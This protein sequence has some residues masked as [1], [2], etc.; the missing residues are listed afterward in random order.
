M[1]VGLGPGDVVLDGE[2]ASPEK[3]ARPHPI[4]GLCPLWPNGWMDQDT[5]WYEVNLGPDDVVLDEVAAS[6]KRGTAPVFGP[7]L[8]WPNGWLMKTPLGTELDLG[9][10]HFVL[11]G[12]AAPHCQRGTA[13]LP[14]FR[15]MS[16]MATI[17]NLSY[18]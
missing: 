16:I 9:P 3:K 15:P 8:L 1:E 12:D 17:T 4:F 13:T 5:T 11:D 18:C 14:S 6:T 10:G 2:P 7:C